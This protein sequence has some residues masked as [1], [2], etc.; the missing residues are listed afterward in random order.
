LYPN[1]TLQKFIKEKGL[2]M[3][4]K[5]HRPGLPFEFR[6][7]DSDVINAFAVPGGYVYLPEEFWRILITKLSLPVC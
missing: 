3:A 4:A 2:L 7:L 6:V 1:D 5:S